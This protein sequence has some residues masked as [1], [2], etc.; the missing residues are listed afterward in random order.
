MLHLLLDV[1]PKTRVS[2]ASSASEN[3]ELQNQWNLYINQRLIQNPESN[4]LHSSVCLI[5]I[6][7]TNS[8][9]T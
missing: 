1:N 8:W 5:V 3:A 4:P 2:R 6:G 7:S 9:I